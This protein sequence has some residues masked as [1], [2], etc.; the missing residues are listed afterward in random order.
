MRRPSPRGGLI[1]FFVWISLVVR[2]LLL[3]FADMKHIKT[4][5]LLTLLSFVGASCSDGERM[6]QRLAEVQACNQADTVFS[7]RW[8]PTV[9]S[10]TDYFDNHGTPNECLLAHYLRARVYHDIG[11]AP[12]ALDEF[13]HAAECAD[14]TSSDCD[15]RTLARVHGQVAE[16]FFNMYLPYETLDEL[17][18]GYKYA[19]RANDTITWLIAYERQAYVYDLMGEK[20]SAEAIIRN[21]FQLFTQYGYNDMAADVLTLII[22]KE[23]ERAE[24]KEAK[25]LIEIFET[26]SNYYQDGKLLNGH[27][28]YC[29]L[30]SK[31]YIGIGESDSAEIVLRKGMESAIDND[32]KEAICKGFT[33][34]YQKKNIPDSVAKYAVLCYQFGTDNYRDNIANELRHVQGLYNYNRNQKIAQEKSEEARQTMK[35]VWTL[36]VILTFVV[37]SCIYIFIIVRQKRKLLWE[38]YVQDQEELENLQE[39]VLKLEQEKHDLEDNLKRNDELSKAIEEEKAEIVLLKNRIQYYEKKNSKSNKIKAEQHLQSLP[40]YKRMRLLAEKPV[41][42]PTEAD[43]DE[44][45]DSFYNIIP[46]LFAF[47]DERPSVLSDIEYRICMLIWLKFLPSE[48]ANLLGISIINVSVIRKRLLKKLFDEDGSAKVFDVKIREFY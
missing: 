46:N 2:S 20:D 32:A 43:W 31:Y 27:E 22:D 5:L 17:L 23:V 29:F 10:L 40:I 9:D 45:K 12:Q 3:N 4:F 35:L 16:L 34:L 8:I 7:A 41:S 39:T 30:K 28:A 38:R 1:L 11:E 21:T 18:L 25:H 19:I 6:R 48:I 15:Y 14:T 47:I 42:I 37:V 36:F 44:L 26:Q 24:W 33:L 13:H